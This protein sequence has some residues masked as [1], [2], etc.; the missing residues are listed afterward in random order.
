MKRARVDLRTISLYVRSLARSFRWTFVT[1]FGLVLFGGTL[2]A[3]TPHAQLGGH[4][5]PFFSALYA[6]WMALFAQAPYA[7]P[8][9]WYLA[10]VDGVYPLLGF[11]LVG[12]GIVRLSLLVISKEQ[13]EK[14]WMK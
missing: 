11:V 12:E 9:T 13:G 2:Y 3:I 4:A 14:E 8:E 10:V 7:P 1:L 5:P 6:A